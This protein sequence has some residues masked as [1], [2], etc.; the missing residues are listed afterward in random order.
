MPI[1]NIRL[2]VRTS[3]DHY[4]KPTLFLRTTATAGEVIS[5]SVKTSTNY[6]KVQYSWV[7]GLNG[8]KYY[9]A[10]ELVL[11]NT[12]YEAYANMTVTFEQDSTTGNGTGLKFEVDFDE[13]G[14]ATSYTIIETG[15]LHMSGDVITT[16]D[17]YAGT[18]DVEIS[19]GGMG[20]TSAP[21]YLLV[22]EGEEPTVENNEIRIKSVIY[23]DNTGKWKEEGDITE[24]HVAGGLYDFT[25]VTGNTTIQVLD[26]T[27]TQISELNVSTLG[28]L[29][30]LDVS[31]TNLTSQ[32]CDPIII[33]LD[34]NG[35]SDTDGPGEGTE[36]FLSVTERTTSG[37]ADAILG[38]ASTQA[39]TSYLNLLNKGW[40]VSAPVL[41]DTQVDFRGLEIGSS[42]Q[43]GFEDSFGTLKIKRY[44]SVFPFNGIETI[45]IEAKNKWSPTQSESG[46]DA[47]TTKFPLDTEVLMDGEY[48]R[49][50][51]ETRFEYT[52]GEK[53]ADY[54]S[55]SGFDQ[56]F[57]VAGENA[58]FILLKWEK[59]SRT[60]TTYWPDYGNNDP[61]SVLVTDLESP[62]Y[63]RFDPVM[64]NLVSSLDLPRGK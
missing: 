38:T 14:L 47:W 21:F 33:A 48:Y 20:S 24:L 50:E 53:L 42:F 19:Q 3:T 49:F 22:T 18:I 13:N 7:G 31:S 16:N 62:D 6:I 41:L 15:Q 54:V 27:G 56:P 28:Q 1:Q 46:H 61:D 35:L 57:Q 52:A 58:G 9:Q 60:F 51:L 32:D 64:Q 2:A 10:I 4:P 45:D 29:R 59:S 39:T 43:S 55:Q 34:E 44:E 23:D 17:A 37:D 63:F 30:Y 40:N 25:N 36:Y 5:G 11:P 8:T 26:L 12:S